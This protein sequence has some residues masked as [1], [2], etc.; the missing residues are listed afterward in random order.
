MRAK[1][2]S[3]G[4]RIFD[5]YELLEMALYYVVP[6]KDTNP[7]AKRLLARFGSLDGVL[8]ASVEDL[9]SVDGIGEKSAS[10]ISQIGK[11]VVEDASLAHRRRV[12]IFNDYH[13]T[14]RFLASYFEDKDTSICMMMLDNGMRLI[15]I[16][17]IPADDFTSAAVKPKYFVNAAL[18]YGASVV[19]IAH[20]RYSMLC[21]SD[22][23]L[24][25]DKLI[26]SE[27]MGVGVT[28]A[29]H[30]VICGKDYAGM[31]S[32]YTLG[33]SS[34]MPELERFLDSIPTESGGAY[35]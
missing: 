20:K 28:V 15:G 4:P 24:A 13:S 29:E 10:F 14:G 31:R 35:D 22:S 3:Y 19:I 30:Y 18:I 8:R 9:A 27:L 1:L 32:G 6:Y 21:F 11:V 17:D 34:D 23:S 12:N 16:E 26:R 2:L 5:T 25:T 33:L 7:I